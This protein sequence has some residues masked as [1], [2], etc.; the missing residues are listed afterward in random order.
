[1][2]FV[3]STPAVIYCSWCGGRA[4]QR[5]SLCRRRAGAPLT[6][7][8][9]VEKRVDP[10]AGVCDVAGEEGEGDV[11]RSLTRRWPAPK[12]LVAALTLPPTVV[13]RAGIR[14]ATPAPRAVR[15]LERAR[16]IE[17]GAIRWNNLKADQD[18]RCPSPALEA[19]L[20]VKVT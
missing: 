5:R 7:G 17:Q 1:M 20:P 4:D 19:A 16:R 9:R 3:A 10:G 2:A 11:V 14:A 8:D 6:P 18:A 13:P 12:A 15:D